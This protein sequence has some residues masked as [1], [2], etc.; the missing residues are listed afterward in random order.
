MNWRAA[1]ARRATIN[2]LL[3]VLVVAAVLPA[4][5]GGQELPWQ[6]GRLISFWDRWIN[7]LEFRAPVRF[8]P[9]E[10]KG[11]LVPYGGPGMFAGLP[12]SFFKEDQT[13]FLLDSTESKVVSIEKFSS[14]LA[15]VYDL[16]LVQINLRNRFLP[17]TVVDMMVGLA[18]RTNQLPLA[19]TL[20]TNWPPGQNYKVAPI[21]HHGLATLTINYQRSA[22]GYAYFQLSRGLATGSVYRAGITGNYL[23]GN[24]TSR[25]YALGYKFF[26]RRAGEPRYAIGLELRYSRLDVPQLDDPEL[27]SPIEGL[28][29]RSLGL[30]FTFSPV[31]GGRPTSA[32]RAKRALYSGDY[33]AAEDDLRAFVSDYPRHVHRRRAERLL[34]LAGRLVPYQQVKL[35]RAMQDEGRLEE[36]LEWYHKAG[37]RG[38][39]TLAATIDSGKAEIG[40]VYLQRADEQLQQG[41]LENTG[42]LLR[43]AMDLVPENED[44]VV[45]FSAEV[46]IRQGHALRT[47]NDF[48]TALKY[49]DRAIS[50]DP[51]R[52]VEIDGYKVRIAE[53]LLQQAFYAADHSALAL[54]LQSLKLG[55]ALDPDRKAEMD[56]LVV[57][58]E[59]RLAGITRGEIQ[60]AMEDQMRMAR[61]ERGRMPP[62]RP[63][64][65]MLVAQVE[66]ILGGPDHR[67][68]HNDRLGVNHQLWE[69]RGGKFPG[70][71][72]FENYQ[73]KRV[74]PLG[75]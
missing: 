70:Q 68:Q 43:I 49:Y 34:A 26:R 48:T 65:G 71:Y 66:D 37:L 36:A 60:K 44:L 5:V 3:G 7:P 19:N 28:E 61:E 16:N 47:Q 20:P 35:A 64:I 69:Y 51:S 30:I 55:R 75:E 29:Q 13:V 39:S 67:T 9:F 15:L 73:L 63:R 62:T 46:L 50:A 45:R 12:A 17:I 11:G 53:D 33:M 32:D 2:L 1:T 4:P 57:L 54:A 52:K 8:I 14:R 58:L 72:Y 22:R 10:L 18:L 31:F 74:E 40:Y 56:S 41:R 38:D 21:F 24:G 59:Q 6:P 23:K 27:L 42:Q 25:D